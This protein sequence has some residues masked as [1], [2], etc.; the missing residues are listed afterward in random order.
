MKK[1]K[2]SED[3][4]NKLKTKLINEIT[5]GTV[6]DAYGRSETLFGNVRSSFQDFYSD[7]MDAFVQDGWDGRREQ[8]PY[9][10]KIK[11]LADQIMDILNKKS[12][13]QD[14]FLD[15]MQSFDREKFHNEGDEDYIEDT[16]M[17][18]LR[19]NYPQK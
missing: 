1:V 9:L 11:E 3:S 6:D 5:Y 18:Y 17:N 12:T 13:Q 8:N 19:K 4:Y 16:E 2:L 14:N 10:V 15:T 7:L